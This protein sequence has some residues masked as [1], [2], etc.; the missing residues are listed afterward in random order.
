LLFCTL[1]D[2]ALD[3]TELRT[4][5]EALLKQ[6]VT[7]ERAQQLLV[8]LDT[9]GDGVRSFNINILQQINLYD[10]ILSEFAST[11]VHAMHK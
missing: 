2:G 3:A 8:A 5:L 6:S 11:V 10:T 7:P 4:G 1:Q 9:N